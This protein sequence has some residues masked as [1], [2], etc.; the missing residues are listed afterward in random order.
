[1]MLFFSETISPRL[2]YIVRLIFCDILH[3]EVLITDD[4]V[5]FQESP[6]PKINYSGQRF[7]DELFLKADPFLFCNTLDYP[8]FKTIKTGD[9]C[10]FF[11]SSGDS[12]LPFD[13]FAASF[14]LVSRFEEYQNS[15]IDAFG[16]FPEEETIAHRL[17]FL[18]K[19]VV[20]LWA[21]SMADRIS[22]KYP[23]KKFLKSNMQFLS[24][25]DV[26]NAWAYL[27]KGFFRSVF[28]FIKGGLKGNRWFHGER[29][30]VLT[31]KMRD[32]YDSYEYL[33]SVFTGNENRVVF[34]FLMG[35]YSKYDKQVHWRNKSYR[36]LIRSISGKYK[37][38][39]HPSYRSSE[40]NSP[41]LLSGEKV[42]LERIINR[43]VFRSRQ[44]Y[45]RLSFP[46]TY[47]KLLETGITEDYSMGFAGNVGFR[48]GICTPFLY[49]DLVNEKVT[50]L[51]VFPFQVMDVTLNQYLHL[52]PAE[53]MNKIELL[54]KEVDG[55]GGL[56]VA[57]W[58][59]ESLSEAGTW[60][61]YRQVFETMNHLGFR[62]ANE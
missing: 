26:D 18:E 60:K 21:W 20:N 54:M 61:N 7:G 8:G 31:G 9:S 48:A 29:F 53:A 57:I 15:R 55:V 46:A 17:G 38:G 52:K 59:N 58:H 22:E 23:E 40:G 11:E 3:S 2:E 27:H 41:S 34:F 10:Y 4:P 13:L 50:S 45:L 14:F 35:S 30:K 25:I 36:N 12:F 43:S 24:T 19:P 47:R 16:R 49:Y 62:Y 42:R 32:P 51:R 6:L 1:M 5:D 28:A 37:V 33:H 44:H 56:F 39:I